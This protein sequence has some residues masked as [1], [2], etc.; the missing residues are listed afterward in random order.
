MS[1]EE[2]LLSN[3]TLWYSVSAGIFLLAMIKMARKPV[4]SALDSG[5]EKIKAELE[6][7]KQLRAEA[8]KALEDYRIRE[9]AALKE[10]E[11]IIAQARLDADRLRTEAEAEIKA[12]LAHQEEKALMRIQDAQDEA[13]AE[14][15]ALLIHQAV[16][17]VQTVLASR[18]DAEALDRLND[19]A[20]SETVSATGTAKG[21]VA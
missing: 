3:T 9:K 7:A 2:S 5:I 18:L 17:K 10:A 13:V 14:V 19:Q 6:Q 15:R 21:R 20:I 12:M 11:D 1:A 8:E 4:A 16:E